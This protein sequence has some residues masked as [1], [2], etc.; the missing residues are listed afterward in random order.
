MLSVGQYHLTLTSLLT[1]PEGQVL[2]I[3]HCEAFPF[4]WFARH[5]RAS[6]R[7]RVTVVSGDSG[8]SGDRQC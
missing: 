4:S 5:F 7:L 2:F 1:F 8:N 3:V 6:C